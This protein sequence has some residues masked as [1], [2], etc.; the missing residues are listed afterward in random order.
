MATFSKAELTAIGV[1]VAPFLNPAKLLYRADFAALGLASI[2]DC[3]GTGAT[4][5][6]VSPPPVDAQWPG[7][8]RLLLITDPLQVTAADIGSVLDFRF[9]EEASVKAL[10]QSVYKSA[11]GTAPMQGAA[12]QS[13]FE[14]NPL[15]EEPTLYAT[16]YLKLQDNL[17]AVLADAMRID[18][19]G[20]W[21]E[22]TCMKTGTQGP[23]GPL[24]NGDYRIQ[25]AINAD[26]RPEPYFSLIGD[27]WAGAFGTRVESFHLDNMEFPVPV[28]Q[29]MRV[30]QF[31]RRSAGPEGRVIFAVNGVKVF[32]RWGPN[33][34]TLG[35]PM[36]RL[37]FPA[38]YS[39]SSLPIWQWIGWPYEL[40]TMPPATASFSA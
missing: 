2:S 40:W 19:Y 37:M 32:D 15:H 5:Q 16:F 17:A 24:A 27:N 20:A 38:L 26:K 10:K 14:F 4:Q 12:T 35:Q 13:T 8:Q 25:V 39:G 30:E 9:T 7:K 21:R 34:G 22:V 33:M 3:W 18:G 11:L 29:W 28:G 6:F 31:T 1:A 23:S 36:N